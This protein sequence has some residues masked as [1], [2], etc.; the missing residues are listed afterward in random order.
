MAEATGYVAG[1]VG[2]VA[3]IS[4]LGSVAGLSG[5]GI[6]SGLATIGSVVGG[7]MVAGLAIT[8]AA[9]AVAALA[10]GAGVH[11]LSQANSPAADQ[12][13]ERVNP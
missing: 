4:S 6:A 13:V 11:Y 9:P 3:A 8:V 7:G 1:I 2:D 12:P 10:V 5:A